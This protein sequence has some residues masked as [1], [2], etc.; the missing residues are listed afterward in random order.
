MPYRNNCDSNPATRLA[1]DR[2]RAVDNRIPE[3]DDFPR[4]DRARIPVRPIGELLLQ[5]SL[6]VPRV[7][8]ALAQV[9]LSE[10]YDPYRD[11]VG[12]R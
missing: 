8:A 11:V 12:G 9:P 7:L 5:D 4:L 1:H 10:I 3:F 6:R 2:G